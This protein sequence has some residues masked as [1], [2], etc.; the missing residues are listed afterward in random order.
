MTA[1]HDYFSG[2]GD[3]NAGAIWGSSVGDD[4]HLVV[5]AEWARREALSIRE[6]RTGGCATTRGPEEE[7]GPTTG[8]QGRS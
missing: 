2:G 3:S 1:A 8:I 6:P 5:S 7:G 4:G